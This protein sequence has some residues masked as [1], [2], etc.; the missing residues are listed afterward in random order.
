MITSD[1]SADLMPGETLIYSW[2]ISARSFFIR[3]GVI[4]LVWV[5]LGQIGSFGQGIS[6]ML[7][8]LPGAV[9]GGAFYMWVFGEFE[10]WTRNRHTA[11]HLTNRAIHI[12]PGDDMPSRLPL[13]EIRRI[14]RWPLWSLV[15]RLNS[16]TATTLPIPPH[17]KKLRHRIM[18]T[19]AHVLPEVTP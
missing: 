9:L 1:G 10:I 6:T 4:V 12:V 8:A 3:A 13:A 5:I 2:R 7:L 16:G 18:S 14:N 19:R 15:L 11:W 17:P